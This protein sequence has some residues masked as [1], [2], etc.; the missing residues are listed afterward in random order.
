MHD[1]PPDD[2][3]S[4]L[5]AQRFSHGENV[6]KRPRRLLPARLRFPSAHDPATRYTVVVNPSGS[7]TCSCPAGWHRRPCWHAR[8]VR[9]SAR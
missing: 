8:T 4:R 9:E 7:V 3:P 2:T 6:P 5:A 1:R